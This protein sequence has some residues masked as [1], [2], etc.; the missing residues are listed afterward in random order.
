MLKTLK[1]LSLPLVL[2]IICAGKTASAR[3]IN[4]AYMANAV[5]FY[6]SAEDGDLTTDTLVINEFMASN[7]NC[8]QDPQGQ[9]DDWVELYNYGTDAIDVGGIYLTDNLFRASGEF[10]RAIR[11]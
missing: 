3:P 11:L 5:V 4:N 10:L 6:I 1:I 7:S 9:Y 8:I 2:S